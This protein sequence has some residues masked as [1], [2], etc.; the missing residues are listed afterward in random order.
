VRSSRAMADQSIDFL[1]LGDQTVDTYIYLRKLLARREH[2]PVLT[3]F[4]YH[5]STT[6][7]NGISSLPRAQRQSLPSFHDLLS[8]VEALREAEC[9]NDAVDNALL[10]FAQLAHWIG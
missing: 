9:H 1:L 7:R 8:F 4:I 6:I 5:V 2:T 3:S 10:C